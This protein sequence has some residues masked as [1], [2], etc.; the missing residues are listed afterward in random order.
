MALGDTARLRCQWLSAGLQPVN[1]ET[2]SVLFHHRVFGI[3][4]NIPRSYAA[5]A[6]FIHF[7]FSE[8]DSTG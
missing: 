1:R 5:T 4:N 3:C 6:D 8:P 2:S 7:V